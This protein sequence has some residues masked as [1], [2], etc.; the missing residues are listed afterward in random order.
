MPSESPPV[1]RAGD[2]E[3]LVSALVGIDDR[4]EAL[5]RA[6][7]VIAERLGWPVGHALVVGPEGALVA[8]PSWYLADPGRF[9]PFRAVSQAAAVGEEGI[10][11][12]LRDERAPCWMED[13]A[14]HLSFLRRRAAAMT[15]IV[16]GAMLPVIAGGEVAGV[17]ELFTDDPAAA[18]DRGAQLRL[19]ALTER[20]GEMLTATR[21]AHLEREREG[22]VRAVFEGPLAMATLDADL[23]II[24]ANALEREVD[25]AGLVQ[26]AAIGVRHQLL[27]QL[28]G[29]RLGQHPRHRRGEPAVD[30]KAGRRAD[31]EQQVGGTLIEERVE[32]RADTRAWIR[33]V[34]LTIP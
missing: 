18:A 14:A 30:A 27:D 21:T 5:P 3:A 1:P 19:L 4:A 32:E 22:R 24:D 12:R 33:H 23:R 20:T 7:A 10:P 8:C 26:R 11:A 13:V 15:G 29:L 28:A 17:L 2:V 25:R 9:E 34:G 16:S 31:A 6:A